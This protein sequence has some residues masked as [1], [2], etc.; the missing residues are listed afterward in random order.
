MDLILQQYQALIENCD[1]LITL[2]SNTS[3][4]VMQTF[5]NISW[6]GFYLDKTD[7][8]QLGPFQG[9]V[10]CEK[11]SYNR[12][13]C[14][15][16]YSQR[17]TLNVPDVHQFEDHIACDCA[18]NSELVIPIYQGDAGIGVLDLDSI[19]YDR[20]DKNIQVLFEELVAILVDKLTM[21][22]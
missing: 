10:A 18:T 15:R 14:G 19:E 11:I 7:H 16:A 6:A 22:R 9:K 1:D 3:A 21:L 4:F 12:G 13:V 8:L 17:E 20:F 5:P 2:Y